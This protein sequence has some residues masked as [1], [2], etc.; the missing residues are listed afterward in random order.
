M[1]ADYKSA[2]AGSSL[3]GRLE[4]TP[5]AR[6][7]KSFHHDFLAVIIKCL[8]QIVVLFILFVYFYFVI[9]M[10]YVIFIF[11][12]RILILRCP[13]QPNEII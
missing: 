3:L 9:K 8:I 12:I 10:I 2:R 1:W 5:Y 6:L 11:L 7:Y 4:G 13:N